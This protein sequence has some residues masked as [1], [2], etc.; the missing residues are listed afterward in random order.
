MELN[1]A[2]LLPFAAGLLA[3][4]AIVLLVLLITDNGSN[5]QSTS[6]AGST[7]VQVITIRGGKP[8]GG[9]KELSY[10]LGDMMHFRFDS[11]TTT[12]LNIHPYDV[13]YRLIAGRGLR[14]DLDATLAT[15]ATMRL[16]TPQE[17][18]QNNAGYVPLLGEPVAE[19]TVNQP[20][21]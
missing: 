19:I 3:G 20:G 9:V 14:V 18:E 15:K 1:R 13:T 8:V 11:D 5:S 12:E 6:T 2:R 16:V 17:G 10:D 4:V 21:Y 7:G